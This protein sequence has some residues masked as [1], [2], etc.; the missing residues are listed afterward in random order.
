MSRSGRAGLPGAPR[1]AVVGGERR[2]HV[3]GRSSDVQEPAVEDAGEIVEHTGEDGP[4]QAHV[5]P[6]ER[7]AGP[8]EAQRVLQRRGERVP[9][10]DSRK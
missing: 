8:R 3:V 10:S 2:Q 1:V 6:V 9:R 5:L 4:G 7:A